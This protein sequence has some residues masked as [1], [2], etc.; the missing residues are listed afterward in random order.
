MQAA[1]QPQGHHM[2]F[3][4]S[5]FQHAEIG[6]PPP[7]CGLAIAKH[8]RRALRNRFGIIALATCRESQ[9]EV[10]CPSENLFQ[11]K[12]I[13]LRL[14]YYYGSQQEMRLDLSAFKRN[15]TGA[16][17]PVQIPRKHKISFATLWDELTEI[18]QR[19]AGSN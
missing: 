2:S 16:T 5:D 6:T 11:D 18:V 15:P 7:P 4:L 3:L 14:Y 10:N 12:S 17:S 9:L 8:Y 19:S 1:D 13:F